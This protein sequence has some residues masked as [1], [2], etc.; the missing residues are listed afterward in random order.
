MLEKL[1]AMMP[2]TDQEVLDLKA[3]HLINKVAANTREGGRLERKIAEI[4]GA[5]MPRF[6]TAIHDR[7]EHTRIERERMG[8]KDKK[9][10]RGWS[11]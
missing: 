1:K 9:A 10:R 5:G 7:A 4:V 11:P 3:R 6:S 2:P 8:W